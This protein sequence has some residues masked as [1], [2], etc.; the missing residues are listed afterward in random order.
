MVLEKCDSSIGNFKRR[1]WV[2][3][4]VYP[5]AMKLVYPNEMVAVR[6]REVCKERHG[7]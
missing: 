5:L 2:S 1:S 4:T 3:V 7:F 6:D